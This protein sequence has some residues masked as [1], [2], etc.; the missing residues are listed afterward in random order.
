[1]NSHDY[2][3]MLQKRLVAMV[4]LALAGLIAA[5]ITALAQPMDAE[6]GYVELSHLSESVDST[7]VKE[8]NIRGAMLRLVR[9]A[10]REDDPELADLLSSVRGVFVRAYDARRTDV[11]LVRTHTKT[12]TDALLSEGWEVFLRVAERSEEVQMYVRIVDDEITG[13]M[14]ISFN[15]L[16]DEIIFVNIV[17]EIDPEKVS[18]LGYRFSSND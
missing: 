11:E 5:P 14:L 16:D 18:R 3:D 1:M 2:K 10:A 7:P 15:L 8:V 13:L 6:P 12:M 4:M 17:G 9:A